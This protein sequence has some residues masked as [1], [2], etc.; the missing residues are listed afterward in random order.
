VDTTDSKDSAN[1]ATDDAARPFDLTEVGLVG[2]PMPLRTAEDY[3]VALRL[4]DERIAV[5]R[6]PVEPV[7]ESPPTDQTP[8]EAGGMDTQAPTEDAGNRGVDTRAA[9]AEPDRNADTEAADD[10][11]RIA[12]LERLR[13]MIERRAAI[14]E[15]VETANKSAALEQEQL[16]RIESDVST[17]SEPISITR[18]DALKAER[19]LAQAKEKRA[20]RR[21]ASARAQLEARERAL[22]EAQ[23]VRRDARD[24]VAKSSEEEQP[25]LMLALEVARLEVLLAVQA[26]DAAEG[27]LALARAEGEIAEVE[28]ARLAAEIGR[29]GNTA[30][31]TET[32]LAERLKLLDERVEGL[33]AR[34]PACAGEATAPDHGSPAPANGCNRPRPRPIDASWPSAS[35]RSMHRWRRQARPSTTSSAPSPTY[36][37]WARSGSADTP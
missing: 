14:A 17:E 6:A 13:Y 26:R 3:T 36:A 31:L 28:Q 23:R 18:L 21:L 2:L 27:Q 20:A 16:A 12:S 30:V 9:G 29:V 19:A 1:D 24:A 11:P 8:G 10:D 25:S 15:Q 7:L 35:P 34:S 37:A 5:L 4:I 22:R 32:D 33:N